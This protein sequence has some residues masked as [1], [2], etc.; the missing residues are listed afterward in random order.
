MCIEI[1]NKEK[2]KS[3]INN[4]ALLNSKLFSLILITKIMYEHYKK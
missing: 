4:D 1:I 2:A 3:V